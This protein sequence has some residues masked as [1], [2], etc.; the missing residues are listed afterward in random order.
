[1]HLNHPKT[2]SPTH[3]LTPQSMEKL[4]SMKLVPGDKMVGDHWT[5]IQ[6]FSDVTGGTHCR[7]LMVDVNCDYPVKVVSIFST[8]FFSFVFNKCFWYD[9][10][11]QFLM[12][13]SRNNLCKNKRG[14]FFF[15]VFLER[16]C[17]R[18]RKFYSREK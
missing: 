4:S 16:R 18:R 3:P 9:T 11:A 2:I 15:F 17:I 5:R 1:M 14:F 8:S 10:A 6:S 12:A 7:P 13:E